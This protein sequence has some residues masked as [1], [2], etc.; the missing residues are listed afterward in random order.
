MAGQGQLNSPL[1]VANE[2]GMI[3]CYNP[4][5]LG[6]LPHINLSQDDPLAGHNQIFIIIIIILWSCWLDH[7]YCGLGCVV[8]TIYG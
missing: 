2:V 5:D 4:I 1:P 3:E 8:Y 6:A 7:R